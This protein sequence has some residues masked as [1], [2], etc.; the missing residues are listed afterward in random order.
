MSGAAGEQQRNLCAHC[1]Q[2]IAPV[3]MRDAD[4]AARKYCDFACRCQA[5]ARVHHHLESAILELLAA[6]GAGFVSPKAVPK[7]YT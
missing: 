5:S 7:L 3:R 2:V 4:R 1:G 6:R